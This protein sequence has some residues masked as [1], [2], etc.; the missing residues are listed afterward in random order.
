MSLCPQNFLS[1]IQILTFELILFSI[2]LI[3]SVGQSIVNRRDYSK[4]ET[5]VNQML[6]DNELQQTI[7]AS[8]MEG[9][10]Q[11]T[12]STGI[13][14]KPWDSNKNSLPTLNLDSDQT[15]EEFIKSKIE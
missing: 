11:T 15:F 7:R 2:L 6:D 14:M 4:F 1:G 12:M 10:V 8:F 13:E 5:L 3:R 9:E